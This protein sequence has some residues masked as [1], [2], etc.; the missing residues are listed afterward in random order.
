[1]KIQESAENYLETILILSKR[2]PDVRS[3]DIVNEM[4]FS[5]P[6]ISN[7]IHRLKKNGYLLMNDK[8]YISLTKR[9]LEIAE[10]IHERH[11]LIEKFL[12]TLGVNEQTA[13]EDACKME[14]AISQESFEK[15]RDH[16]YA[17]HAQLLEQ[18]DPE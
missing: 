5:K 15:M 4:G 13:R 12:M 14:H 9:G 1:M 10:R 11:L 6:S 7:A 17:K 18:T 16:Y 8:G 2:N 3:I